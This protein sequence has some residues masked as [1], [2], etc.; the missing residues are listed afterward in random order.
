MDLNEAKIIAEMNHDGF[1]LGKIM[2]MYPV[3]HDALNWALG[4]LEASKTATDYAALVAERDELKRRCE[5]IV[6]ELVPKPSPPN[7]TN[8]TA[9]DVAIWRES[10]S[11]HRR[12]ERIAEGRDK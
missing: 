4:E 6:T 8:P 1:P 7:P 10:R 11:I 5:K 3:T 9:V 2:A 12:I